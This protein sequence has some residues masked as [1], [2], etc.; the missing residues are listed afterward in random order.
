MLAVL[1]SSS[2]DSYTP[3]LLVLVESFHQ[4]DYPL[5]AK[6]GVSGSIKWKQFIGGAIPPGCRGPPPKRRIHAGSVGLH[7]ALLIHFKPIAAGGM[8][9]LSLSLSPL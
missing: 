8:I 5:H 1:V 4:K 9:S 7:A 2:A 6:V 3:S